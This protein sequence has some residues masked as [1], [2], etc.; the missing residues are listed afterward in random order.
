MEFK[1]LDIHISNSGNA[2]DWSY[3]AELASILREL[4]EKIENM[5]YVSQL[6]DCNGNKCGS[7]SLI[8][9][10]ESEVA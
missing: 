10:D 4:A 8:V 2:F 9:E 6:R 3:H 7:V 5:Q 1:T